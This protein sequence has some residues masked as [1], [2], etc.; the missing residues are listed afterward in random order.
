MPGYN[1]S[2]RITCIYPGDKST[3]LNAETPAS[4]SASLQ[5]AIGLFPFVSSQLGVGLQFSAAPGAFTINL[6]TS[7]TTDTDAAYTAASPSI[8]TVGTGNY[9]MVNFPLPAGAMWARLRTVTANANGAACTA[10][11]NNSTAPAGGGGTAG[12]SSLN[13]LTG[14][15]AIQAGAGITVTPAGSNITI[16]DN[17]TVG[18]PPLGTA[19]GDLGGSYPNPVVNGIANATLAS[20]FSAAGAASTPAV[21]LTGVPYTGGTGTTTSPLM[22]LDSGSVEPTS[23]STA[24]TI[25]GMNV[26]SGFTGNWIDCHINGSASTF[27]VTSGGNIT[28]NY[29]YVNA[30]AWVTWGNVSQIGAAGIKGNSAVALTW[31]SGASTALAVDTT[32]NRQAAGILQIAS[33]T[34]V[35]NTGALSLAQVLLNG[36]T[37]AASTSQLY[38][39]TAPYTAGTTTT[40]FPVALF[41]SSGGS[42][43]TTWSTTGT[44]L[45][46]NAPSGF[47]GNFID[48]H[49]N[50]GASLLSVLSNGS[51]V[52]GPNAAYTSLGPISGSGNYYRFASTAGYS[53]AIDTTFGRASAGV[54]QINAGSTAGSTGSLK[55]GQILGGSGTPAIAGGTGAGTSPTVN[56][57]GSNSAGQ[58]TVTTGTTPT[59]SGPV[60]TIT[61]AN[62]FAYPAAPYP[63][64]EPGNAAAAALTGTSAVFVTSTTTTFVI[65]AGTAALAAA[66]QYIW[67][68]NVQG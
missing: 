9:I 1:S 36:G 14:A 48:F 30:A 68:Y 62:S 17:G 66:T 39:T 61:F 41:D 34:G 27:L 28:C 13:A 37:P 67:Y 7:S 16:I 10:T 63:I 26:P 50:G 18:G 12:V 64:L 53:G 15:L 24:G 4:G 25:L 47:T 19:G 40:N 54:L 33:G 60:I 6:E 31:S 20:K 58:V 23:W 3:V 35:G 22:Y 46:I 49:V 21:S 57:V 44:I 32:L 42:P 55:L 8:T 65:N 11:I 2:S 43:V 56:V 29:V 59:A 51:I 5:V 52:I 38:I 45:G